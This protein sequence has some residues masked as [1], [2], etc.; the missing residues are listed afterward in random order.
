MGSV[1]FGEDPEDWIPEENS[2]AADP[3]TAEEIDD[4]WIQFYADRALAQIETML[5]AEG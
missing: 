2:V 1:T 4:R 3:L 5:N